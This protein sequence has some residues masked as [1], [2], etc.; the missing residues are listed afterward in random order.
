MSS[1]LGEV[2]KELKRRMHISVS[3]QGEWLN[4][5]LR[6]HYAYFAVP[7]N[8]RVLS[9]FRYHVA[10]RWMKSLRRRSQR[11][12]MTWERMAIYIDQYLPKP[13]ILHPWPEQ[14]FSVKHSS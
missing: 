13:K 9:A 14:R 4:S 8:T 10:R 12:R 5:V 6:G 1:K 3:E 11:H 7:T 2:K